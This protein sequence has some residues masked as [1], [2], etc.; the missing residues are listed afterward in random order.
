MKINVLT[1]KNAGM[2]L[3]EVVIALTILGILAGGVM[4]SFGY[5]FR[6]MQKVRDNQRATQI[7]LEKLETIRLYSWTQVNTT[8]F[9]PSTFTDVYDP[10]G[11]TGQK[12]ITFNGRVQIEPFPRTTSYAAN[13]KQLVITLNWSEDGMS[14]ERSIRTYIGKNGLQNYVY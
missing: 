1:R 13:L 4:A 9:I 6:N 5:G 8:G 10:Q 14:H 11:A 2:T 3:V 7:L 12:G